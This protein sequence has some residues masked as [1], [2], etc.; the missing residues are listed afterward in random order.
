MIRVRRRLKSDEG[1]VA[2]HRIDRASLVYRR[3]DSEYATKDWDG[4]PK[5]PA[6]LAA[7]TL[8]VHNFPPPNRRQCERC[9]RATNWPR[10][11][12]RRNESCNTSITL[13][14]FLH[15]RGRARVRAGR[16]VRQRQMCRLRF[17]AVSKQLSLGLR[18]AFLLLSVSRAKWSG[19]G[20]GE[21]GGV[22]SGRAKSSGLDLP[23]YARPDRL[24]RPPPAETLIYYLS[25][26]KLKGITAERTDGRERGGAWGG[27]AAATAMRVLTPLCL[28]PEVSPSERARMCGAGSEQRGIRQW[29]R[30]GEKLLHTS[31]HPGSANQGRC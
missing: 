27:D 7:A 31:I 9:V 28:R 26:S 3:Q 29:R 17:P 5:P 12:E 18:P 15:E 1:I 19:G 2:P 25:H 10:P 4:P 6:A 20:R 24:P 30:R 22:G 13:S 14:P 16:W 21:G 8:S 23:S 11:R